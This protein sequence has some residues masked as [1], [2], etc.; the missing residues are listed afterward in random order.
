MLSASPSIGKEP[1]PRKFFLV[2]M[3]FQRFPQVRQSL[4]ERPALGHDGDLQAFR[5]ISAF[6]FQ[7]CGANGR[8]GVTLLYMARRCT[9][10]PAPEIAPCIGGRMLSKSG[11]A[12]KGHPK[13]CMAYVRY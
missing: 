1:D 2:E 3:Q 13:N 12:G 10:R 7:D 11:P 9:A 8:Q 6:A 5:H 4:I